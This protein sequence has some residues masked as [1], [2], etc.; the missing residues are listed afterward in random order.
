MCILSSRADSNCWQPK[1][2]GQSNV[3][4]AQCVTNE[5]TNLMKLLGI[6][7]LRNPKGRGACLPASLGPI[8]DREGCPSIDRTNR[9]AVSNSN[10]R[11][12][13]LLECVASVDECMRTNGE[14]MQSIILCTFGSL[15]VLDRT[16]LD[17]LAL[18]GSAKTSQN[19]ITNSYDICT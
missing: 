3:R 9:L 6:R 10:D 18:P 14:H 5:C 4:C 11:A 7:S 8:T 1:R 17:Q 16:D 13:R 15:G 12:T 2:K 19:P